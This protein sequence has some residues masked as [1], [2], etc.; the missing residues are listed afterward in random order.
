[1]IPVAGHER[2]PGLDGLRGLALVIVLLFH[3]GISWALG[4]Y[5]GVSMFFTL[6][7][8]L[9]TTLLLG[10]KRSTGRISLTDFWA[11]R[12]RRLLPAAIAGL[13]LALVA[14]RLATPFADRP[15]ALG[16]VRAAAFWL[17]NWRFIWQDAVYADVGM[18]PSPVQHFWSL[19]IEEQFYLVFPVIAML[20]LRRSRA[21][22]G[23]VLGAIAV[24]AT[25]RQVAELEHTR[26][27]FGTDTRAAELA[28]GGL[29]ALARP[30]L[31]GLLAR[32][33]G[34]RHLPDVV[35][36]TA[37]VAFTVLFLRVPD[38]T[39]AL[40][41]GGF[42]GISILTSM[43]IF[44]I[45]DGR[46]IGRVLSFRPLVGLGLISY[47]TYLYHFPVFVIFTEAAT[48]LSPGPLL[49]WRM[50]ITLPMAI[51]S[52]YL[53]ERPIRMRRRL[54]G[55]RSTVAFVGGLAVVLLATGVY[56]AR[57]KQRFEADPF[58]AAGLAVVRATPLD[59]V[60]APAPTTSAPPATADVATT[61]VDPTSTTAVEAVPATTTT[62]QAPAPEP[63]LRPP[64]L[65]IVGDS[66]AEVMANG[67]SAW[68][69]ETGRLRVSAVTSSG[70]TTYAGDR[71][72]VRDG[73]EFAPKGCA[74]LFPSA[75][76]LAGEDPV[77]AVFVLI[78]SSQLS[79]WRYPGRSGWFTITDAAVQRAYE[80]AL[81][82]ALA[83]LDQ[84]QVPI[85][86]ADVPP[87][88]W[89]LEVFG[90][91]L[92]GKLPGHGSVKMNEPARYAAL[93]AIDDRVIPRHPTAAYVPWTAALAGPDGR[94]DADIRPDG[95]H[96]DDQKV[97]DIAE[98]WLM[99][100]L[101]ESYD[102]VVAR[103][104]GSLRT[105]G[106]HTWAPAGISSSG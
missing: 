12:A 56:D 5:L 45:V 1:M 62:T 78:G 53:L 106:D 72:R 75:V 65:L 70:C 88:V 3:G 11:R 52:Y 17:A 28:M 104:G 97:D 19:A 35:G 61:T 51:A 92:G 26:V 98:E 33:P 21:A 30:G 57:L 79:D 94:I 101:D 77:D 20:A 91:M 27:Y 38:S 82:D 9:I 23:V 81:Q 99:A 16:D 58:A 103:A 63:A 68:A 74:E 49:A 86:W 25:W 93:R 95:L 55:Q 8:F 105:P 10:E 90:S 60:P 76:R 34:G 32:T 73:Y 47:G 48:G 6:S 43:L 67:L 37:L 2:W 42:T 13:A 31:A 50:G 96:V 59:E 18:L 89:D 36:G 14:V 22:L 66:T 87:P 4:G 54:L 80:Q 100:L 71:L 69:E 46:I 64:H 29:L 44:G 39:E 24:L 41:D 84:L 7:G 40:Y 102:E 83:T 15:T 85:L